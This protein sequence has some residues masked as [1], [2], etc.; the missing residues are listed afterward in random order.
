MDQDLQV[1]RELYLL[2]LVKRYGFGLKLKE[3][4]GGGA[5]PRSPCCFKSGLNA[6]KK[7]I[8]CHISLVSGASLNLLVKKKTGRSDSSG[9]V[10]G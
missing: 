6:F 10:A 8:T 5:M 9:E 2:L 7:M 3:G 1:T 4:R